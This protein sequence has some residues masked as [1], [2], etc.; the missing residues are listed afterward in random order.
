MKTSARV[1]SLFANP[2]LP[3]PGAGSFPA[4]KPAGARFP[5]VRQIM[6]R[7]LFQAQ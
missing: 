2:V 4:E 3:V 5:Q 1:P 7:E 6:L